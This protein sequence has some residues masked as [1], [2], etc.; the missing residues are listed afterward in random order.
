MSA[1]TMAFFESAVFLLS[2]GLEGLA[3][4]VLLVALVLLFVCACVC[5]ERDVRKICVWIEVDINEGRMGGEE[6]LPGVHGFLVVV[7][8]VA[9]VLGRKGGRERH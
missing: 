2:E 5:L 6:L 9:A 7:A 1:V 8:V 3:A 4:L